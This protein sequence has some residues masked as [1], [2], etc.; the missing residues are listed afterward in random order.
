MEIKL[1]LVGLKTLEE[2]KGIIDIDNKEGHLLE[3]D[4]KGIQS[5]FKLV[6]SDGDH[7]TLYLIVIYKV[8]QLVHLSE[9]VS[10]TKTLTESLEEMLKE[11][12]LDI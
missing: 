4:I 11:A 5:V 8:K 7:D 10:L 12:D 9:S 3:T 1:H 2:L 6:K